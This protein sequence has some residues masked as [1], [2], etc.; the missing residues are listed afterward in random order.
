VIKQLLGLLLSILLNLISE[1]WIRSDAEISQRH[2]LSASI[3]RAGGSTRIRLRAT[4]T[5]QDQP[6]WCGWIII[7]IAPCQRQTLKKA[8]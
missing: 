6:L 3:Y 8:F 7:E 5:A 4:T 2:A 1:L